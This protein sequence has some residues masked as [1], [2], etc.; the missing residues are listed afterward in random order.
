MEFLFFLN[1]AVEMP[2]LTVSSSL[3]IWPPLLILTSANPLNLWLVMVVWWLVLMCFSL[4]KLCS[5][6]HDVTGNVRATRSITCKL[7][8]CKE[9]LECKA[10]TILFATST[11][12]AC[13]SF[14]L[15]THMLYSVDNITGCG[16]SAMYRSAA[17]LEG[18]SHSQLECTHLGEDEGG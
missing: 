18:C 1:V 8:N 9:L 11:L 15:V 2:L 7:G 16:K 4:L 5:L 3:P 10:S 14:H 17:W 13:C 12:A 6:S